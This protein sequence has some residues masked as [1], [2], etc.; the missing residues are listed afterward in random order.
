MSYPEPE[1]RKNVGLFMGIMR[2]QPLSLALVVMNFVLLGF[3]FYSGTSQLSQRQ[4]TSAMIV[5][6][7]QATDTLMAN[8]VSSD[9]MQMVLNALKDAHKAP[10]PD[11]K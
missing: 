10:A 8:C 11:P 5:K 7:Q 3:L 2:D 6:W 9:I 4:E 1:R